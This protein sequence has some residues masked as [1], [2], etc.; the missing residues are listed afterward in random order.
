MDNLAI[1]AVGG[2]RSRM[3]SLDLLA[4][5]LANS[6]T[7]GYK[8]DREFY[9]IYAAEDSGNGI[10]GGA[11]MALPVVE[12][13]W[14]DFSA[15]VIQTTG[16]PLDVAIDGKGFLT[17]TGPQGPLYTRNGNLKILPAGELATSDGYPV[18]TP[19]GTTIKVTAGQQINITKEGNVQ[20]D[21]QTIGQI[22]LITFPSTEPLQKVGNSNFRNTDPNNLPVPVNNPVVEQGKIEGSNVP[23]AYSA[24]RLVAIMR[25]FEML[26]KAIGISGEM[27]TK[28]IQEVARVGS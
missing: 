18:Q 15:G 5:N 25:Q 22:G 13:Q 1:A 27:D 16:N 6:A 2:L 26:Q 3:Q 9:G 8:S 10:D 11:G 19:G 7:S 14:S 12:K 23:V 4:N 20:Q 17:V 21:G 28:S 24:M